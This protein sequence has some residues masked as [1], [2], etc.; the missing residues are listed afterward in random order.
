MYIYIYIY[1]YSLVLLHKRSNCNFIAQID[2]LQHLITKD[3]LQYR[4]SCYSHKITDPET[5]VQN[6][7]DCIR[8]GIHPP[9]A[10]LMKKT[11]KNNLEG[12]QKRR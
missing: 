10:L 2:E 7:A 4:R 1:I 11:N 8:K 3:I 9:Y 12:R 6:K 5:V